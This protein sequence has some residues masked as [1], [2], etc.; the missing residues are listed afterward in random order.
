MRIARISLVGVLVFAAAACDKLRGNASPTEPSGPLM[1]L[2][3]HGRLTGYMLAYERLPL[4]LEVLVGYS[5][6][7]T[8]WDCW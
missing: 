8:A 6:L 2:E 4:E 5:A 1:V 3:G 7:M